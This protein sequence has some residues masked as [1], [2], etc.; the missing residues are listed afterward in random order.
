MLGP[1]PCLA[2]EVDVGVLMLK[3]WVFVLFK[4]FGCWVFVFLKEFSPS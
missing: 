3:C 4:G 2:G 1:S